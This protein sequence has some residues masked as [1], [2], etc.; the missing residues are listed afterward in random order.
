MSDLIPNDYTA[1]LAEVKERI[2]TAQYAALRAV[3][4][5]LIGL[6]WDIGQMIVTRQQGETWGKSVVQRLAADLRH[7]FHGISGFRR[8]TCGG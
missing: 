4:K 8:R 5:E 2:R 6:Y 7:E 3:N 1:L